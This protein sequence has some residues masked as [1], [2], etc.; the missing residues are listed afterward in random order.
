MQWTCSEGPVARTVAGPIAGDCD[1]ILVRR[2][3]SETDLHQ[4]CSFKP[5]LR[6]ARKALTDDQTDDQTDGPI[7]DPVDSPANDYNSLVEIVVIL[8]VNVRIILEVEQRI[9][10]L[11][12]LLDQVV[13]DHE[14]NE[15]DQTDQDDESLIWT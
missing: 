6:V 7:D 5:L 1:H 4:I 3:S 11:S 8:D 13:E 9:V 15:S 12:G 14:H 10:V 2:T